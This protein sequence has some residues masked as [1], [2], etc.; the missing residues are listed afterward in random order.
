MVKVE[1][2]HTV[3]YRC[4]NIRL[5][6]KVIGMYN[7][8]CLTCTP[9]AS[10]TNLIAR[11]NNIVSAKFTMDFFWYHFLEGLFAIDFLKLCA[12]FEQ[13]KSYFHV[14]LLKLEKYF[15]LALT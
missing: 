12:F 8:L 6:F 5:L 9:I 2:Y 14:Q 4:Q 13:R 7:I 3:H 15:H 1:T 11:C 10:V